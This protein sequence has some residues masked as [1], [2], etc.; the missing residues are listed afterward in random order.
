MGRGPRGGLRPRQSRL[1]QTEIET[2][3]MTAA[4][5]EADPNGVQACWSC[6]GPVVSAA[7]FC[8]TCGAVQPPGQGDHFTRLGLA[9]D[10]DV[11]KTDLDQRYFALQR[12]L[13]PDRFA[14]RAAREREISLQQSTSLNQAYETVKS[15][16]RRAE[17]LLSLNGVTVNAETGNRPTDPDVLMEA[18]ESREAL[19]EAETEAEIAALAAR[20]RD[21]QKQCL[22]ALAA[23]FRANDLDAAARLAVRL[24]YLA[25]FTEEARGRARAARAP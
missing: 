24:K 18:M 5:L 2:I 17:Y 25:T 23:A 10:F 12:D 4:A 21:S 6:K 7:M 11:D 20:T 1:V 9:R 16:L 22:D 8:A 13:H 19:A 14:T 15:P 3:A